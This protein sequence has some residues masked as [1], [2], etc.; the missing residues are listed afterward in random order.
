ME[1]FFIISD[2]VCN[3]I[4]DFPAIINPL[5]LRSRRLQTPGLKVFSWV[6][7][8]LL[9]STRYE[10][11]YSL[12]E[13]SSFWAFW[14]KIPDG[15]FTMITFSSSYTT[16]NEKWGRVKALLFPFPVNLSMVSSVI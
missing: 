7:D 13:M 10:I 11:I 4:K 1:R 5:V 6:A 16:S 15:L 14:L 12:I 8:R 3:P 9:V 2:I